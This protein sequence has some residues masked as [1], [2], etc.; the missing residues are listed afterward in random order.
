MNE[1]YERFARRNEQI[2]DLLDEAEGLDERDENGRLFFCI[3][4]ASVL[5][6]L[7]KSEMRSLEHTRVSEEEYL[8]IRKIIAGYYSCLLHKDR[9]VEKIRKK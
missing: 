5:L 9:V 4:K 6:E 2:K 8:E 3:R 7:Q 1:K